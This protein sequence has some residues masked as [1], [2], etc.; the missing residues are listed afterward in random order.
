M[1]N[2]IEWQDTPGC[3]ERHLQRRYR[4]PLFPAE[5]REITSEELKE[6]RIKDDHDQKE[7]AKMYGIFFS[8]ANRLNETSPI[9]DLTK[10]LQDT[11]YLLESAS[12][13]GGNLEEEINFLEILE[14][15]LTDILNSRL[16]QGVDILKKAHSLSTMNRIPYLAQ[17]K[18]PDT[19]ILKD[20]ALPA[21]LSEDIETIE[22]IGFVS[23]SFPNFKPDANDVKKCL[24]EAI[25]NGLDT[26][27]AKEVIEAWNSQE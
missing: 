24:D 26:E 1:S 21:L 12:S 17:S 16:P 18:R 19:P 20:E 11:Q 22:T 14:I 23:R 13:V 9:N 6:A 10:C 25:R 8:E 7:F 2:Q 4:N 15:K 27:Y 5:R 3:F